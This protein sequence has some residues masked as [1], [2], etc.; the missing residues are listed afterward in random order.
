MKIKKAIK[1]FIIDF[2][3]TF[4]QSE[5]LEE[6]AVVALKKN[7]D[8]EL[9][10]KKI[11]EITNLGMDGKILYDESLRKRLKLLHGNK[12]H[13]NQVVNILKKKISLS[14]KRNRPFFKLF[15][16]NIY[17]ISGGFKEFIL[18]IV[19]TFGIKKSHIFANTFVLDRAGKIVGLD[20]KN[21]L[22]QH[23]G[24]VKVVKN[25]RLTGETI[26]VGDGYSDYEIKAMG[27]AKHF[28]AFTENVYREIVVQKADRVV[29]SFD[30]FL[31]V[32]NLPM[33]I[34]YPKSKVKVLLLENINNQAVT[35]FEH[36]GYKVEYYEKSLSK[37]EIL[38]KLKDIRILGVRSRTNIDKEI[39]DQGQKLLTIGA[40]CIGTNQINLQKAALEGIAVFNAPY[41]NTRSVVEMILGEIIML[42]RGIF[43][44]SIKLHQGIWDKS[45]AGSFEVRGKKLGIIGYGN[46]GSQLS[47]LAESLG[48]HV[49][50]F[51]VVE[52]MP[53]GN[54]EQC[55][56][57]KDLL[58]ISDIITVHVDGNSDNIHLISENEFNLMK[59]G[60]IFL[61]ASRGFVVDLKAL[62]KNLRSGKVRGAAIDVFPNE[63]KGAGEAYVSRLQGMQN[64]ILTPH[65]GGS[66]IEAQKNIGVFVAGKIIDY[67]N[68]G[69]TH[70]SVNFPNIHLPK[71][72]NFHRLLHVH[73]N[74]PGM[75]A[76]I[77]STLAR[78]HIN[79]EGQYLK[80]TEDIGYA[81]TDVNK[82]YDKQTI[83]EL[84]TI[85]NTIRFRLLY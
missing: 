49:Y 59:D 76:S 68:A 38:N 73:R 31:Y 43:A 72:G 39:I 65:I 23:G 21:P 85:E 52:R 37:F 28:I 22:S 6:L 82:F 32:N 66:T 83:K 44:K 2:D 77:N 69:N 3:S 24:K 63:P 61:N 41:S 7:P 1:Y 74:I 5:G 26:V 4:V 36:E 13:I 75:L 8:R 53:L 56:N 55:N 18:P 9:T 79:I 48:M 67:I 50:F 14:I 70:L 29:S 78:F 46:I 10:I 84:K 40:F 17:I 81:I 71:Q 35:D 30:E 64:V 27:A 11:K 54:A 58:S 60:V 20:S 12:L 80:T 33:S 19:K 62:E 16:D 42:S 47:T 15:K 34:S 45:T 57:L 25:L 51:D